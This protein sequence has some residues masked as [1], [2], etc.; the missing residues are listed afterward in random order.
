MHILFLAENYQYD[1]DRFSIR[2]LCHLRIFGAVI[3]LS[4]VFPK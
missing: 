3:S 2:L 1:T 4:G